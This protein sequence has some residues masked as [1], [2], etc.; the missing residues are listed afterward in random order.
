MLVT[1]K[2]NRR[3]QY[4]ALGLAGLWGLGAAAGGLLNPWAASG[5]LVSPVIYYFVRR[6]TLRRRQVMAQPFPPAW[7]H[8]LRA[9]VAYFNALEESD[10]ERFRQLVKIFLDEVR[11]TGIQT[12]VDDLCQVL[13]AASA[14]I[15]VFGFPDWEYTRLGEVLVYPASFDADF[16][17]EQDGDAVALGMVGTAHLSGVMILSKPALLAGFDLHQDKH[18]VGIHE[19]AHLVDQADG[20]VD[21]IPAGVTAPLVREWISWVGRELDRE[22]A[23]PTDIDTY[24]Y[25][26][27]AEYLAVL[28]EYFFEAPEVLKRKHP[29]LYQMLKKMYHQDTVSFLPGVTPW[30]RRKVG[31]N[32]PCPCGSGQKYK[33]CCLKRAKQGIPS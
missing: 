27:K 11:I 25:T 17:T 13:I 4:W 10:R 18:N 20:L 26:N 15:P 21:G 33:K 2:T 28:T 12:E 24:A 5:V 30:R 22:Q 23:R 9:R 3:N 31:R 29:Q 6:R 1:P 32:D 7:E 16:S 19:F 14:V 8:I